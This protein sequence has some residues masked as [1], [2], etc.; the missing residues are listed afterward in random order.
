MAE[1]FHICV[2]GGENVMS[3]ELDALQSRIDELLGQTYR[4][5]SENRIREY[6]TNGR[7]IQG[8]R[9]IFGGFCA[10]LAVIGVGEVFANTVGFVRQRKRE[11]ARYMSV[12]MT[13]G[14]IRK[15]FCIEALEI[16]RAHV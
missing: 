1:D 13:P 9:V 15:M 5:E 11:F 8:M 10:L 6:E 14:E 3:E 16:G 12:G 2:L 4:T 7:Q